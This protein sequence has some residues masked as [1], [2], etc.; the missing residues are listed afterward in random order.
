MVEGM[1]MSLRRSL[2]SNK[3][4]GVGKRVETGSWD[5]KGRGVRKMERGDG[6]GGLK[7]DLDRLKFV[8]TPTMHD[9]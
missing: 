8:Y 9:P 6:R 4:F 1:R 5:R 2:T 3:R 7:K